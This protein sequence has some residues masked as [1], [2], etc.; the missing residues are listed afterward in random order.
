MTA[1]A[2]GGYVKPTLVGL[3]RLRGHSRSLAHTRFPLGLVADGF[4][5]VAVGVEHIGAVVVGVV[6]RSDAGR[7]VVSPA[8]L[9]RCRMEGIYLRVRLG[10][11]RN[12]KSTPH[13][14]AVARWRARPLA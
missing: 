11:Q 8:G 5:V 4:D 2:I 3:L 9:D 13:R 6:D 7:T 12:V 14:L 10:S 1:A